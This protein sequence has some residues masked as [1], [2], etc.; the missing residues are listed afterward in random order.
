MIEIIPC[1]G[2]IDQLGVS[3]SLL[4]EPSTNMGK[5]SYHNT[6]YFTMGSWKGVVLVSQ[7]KEGRGRG[8]EDVEVV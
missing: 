6:Y 2:W 3:W 7:R 5:C 1:L 8:R 4:L